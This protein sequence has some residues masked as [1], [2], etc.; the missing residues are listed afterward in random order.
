MKQNYYEILEVDKNASPEIIK[1]A[2][3][4]L[5]KKYHPDLQNDNVKHLYEEKLKLINEAYDVLSNEK[6]RKSYNQ[7]IVDDYAVL[8]EKVAKLSKENAI[9]RSQY[10]S[11]KENIYPVNNY[12]T[13]YQTPSNAYSQINYTEEQ[14]NNA[15]QQYSYTSTV[16]DSNNRKY[17]KQQKNSYKNFLALFLTF[18]ILLLL[19]KIPFIQD[20]ILNN[21]VLHAIFNIF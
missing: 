1:K 6:Q 7:T 16:Q 8:E 11:L 12:Q 15:E 18:V 10:Q 20:F 5:V 14:S 13:S 19:Y 4:T 2:Y 3:S 21:P 9:L 17:K